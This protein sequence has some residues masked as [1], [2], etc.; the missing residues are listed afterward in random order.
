M[1]LRLT[2]PIL[3]PRSAR[4]GVAGTL[5]PLLLLRP[6][7]LNSALAVQSSGLGGLP[8]T[9]STCLLRW[10]AALQAQCLP[11]CVGACIASAALPP[12]LWA[13]PLET[14]HCDE[15][16]V[17][18]P[19]GQEHPDVSLSS[20]HL[21]WRRPTIRVFRVITLITLCWRTAASAMPTPT[22]EGG[23]T[24]AFAMRTPQEKEQ[25]GWRI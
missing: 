1:F 12:Y 10:M 7:T 4:S 25:E 16:C 13:S 11:P 15:Q 24:A 6:L 2:C 9:Y 17:T 23:G 21:A 19:T 20:G 5:C 3:R 14:Q 22:L 8:A 18:C